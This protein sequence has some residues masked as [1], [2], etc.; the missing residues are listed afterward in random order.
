MTI[1]KKQ[2]ISFTSLLIIVFFLGV[3][4]VWSL[5]TVND[6][7]TVIASTIVPQLNLA[8][9]MRF[10]VASIRSACY[11]HISTLDAAGM[12]KVEV[13]LNQEIADLTSNMTAYS[14]LTGDQ[15]TD[16]NA[17]WTKYQDLNTQI[18]KYSHVNDTK[19]AMKIING[20]SQT[21]YNLMQ[22]YMDDLV[23]RKTQEIAAQSALGDTMFATIFMIVVITVIICLML[24]FLL[25]ILNIRAVTVPIKK[26]QDR[27]TE[28][29]QNGGDLTQSIQIKTKDEVGNLA[30]AMNQ[31]IENVRVIILE[32]NERADGVG[33]SASAV[34]EKLTLLNANLEDSSATVEELSAGMEETAASA[35]EISAS[36]NEI[37]HAASAISSRASE[38]SEAVGEI[39]Q[40]AINLQTKTQKSSQTS[41]DLF[42]SSREKLTKALERSK[43]IEQITILTEAILEISAQTNLLALNAAIEAARAGEAGK[44]FSVVADEIGR[45]ADNSKQTV[46]KIQEVTVDVV[47]SVQDLSENTQVFLNYFS[48]TVVTDYADMVATGNQYEKDAG[49]VDGLVND[50]SSTSKKLNSTITEIINA[51]S[52]VATTISESANGTQNIAERITDIVSLAN[53]IQT[54]MRSTIENSTKLKAAV[55]KFKV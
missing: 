46:E 3:L 42:H 43:E 2:I 18:L 13:T 53:D 29:V 24:G 26:L 36:S 30:S 49:F 6:K 14:K 25:E 28:L 7:S 40:R 17:N 47:S 20:D 22:K 52:E 9:K 23:N 15:M 5:N 16:F 50:F 51:I 19:N 37:E 54:E 48:D 27:L 35:Q 10:E 39:S 4:S 33:S 21:I 55:G 1:K 41:I 32:V 38:G 31:F 34:G 8:N 11:Q 45:L 12:Q 44:G